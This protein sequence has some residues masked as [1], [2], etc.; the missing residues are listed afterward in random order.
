M[1]YRR[2]KKAF[3]IV[4]LLSA[5]LYFQQGNS[6]AGAATAPYPFTGEAAS[7][8]AIDPPLAQLSRLTAPEG[9]VDDRLGWSVA[10]SGETSVVGAYLDDVGANGDQ[11]W[12]YVFVRSGG[13]WSFQ[14]KLTANDGGANDRFGSSVAINSE[15]IVVGSPR[16]DTGQN[17]DQGAAYVFVRS[18]TNWSIQQKLTA[19][20]GAAGDQFGSSVAISGDAVVIG[21]PLDNTATTD[22]QGAAYV[23]ARSGMVWAQQQKLAAND[24]VAGDQFGGAVALAL[25]IMADG[26]QSFEPVAQFDSAQ[27]RFVSVPIDLGPAT[28]QV[29]LVLYGTGLK[30]RSSLSAV[31]C[32]IG[33]VNS[34]VLFVGAAPVFAGVDQV[35]VRLP[36]SL[37]GRGEV[38]IALFV[39]SKAANHVRVGVR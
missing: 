19:N 1:R 9:A 33:G 3:L 4:I 37:A 21:A 28:D 30:Y 32:S 8:L 18:G 39:D 11:G 7:S 38:D 10:V 36:R 15:T 35:N 29:F 14:Q 34:E 5:A 23:F 26:S 22:D 25:R 24:G 17:L 6:S 12:A 2:S 27:N 16:D 31:S 20:D 13:V